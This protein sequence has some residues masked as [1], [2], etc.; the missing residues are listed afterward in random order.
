MLIRMIVRMPGI[1]VAAKRCEL[2]KIRVLR[3]D[4]NDR[5]EKL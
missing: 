3:M 1:S 5:D 2:R 4:M